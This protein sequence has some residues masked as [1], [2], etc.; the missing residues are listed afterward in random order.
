MEV[1]Q[2]LRKGR[3]LRWSTNRQSIERG[4]LRGAEL[5]ELQFAVFAHGTR[6]KQLVK[7]SQQHQKPLRR[8][9][10]HIIAISA[11]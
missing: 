5:V 8:H 11:E 3:K 9:G 7:E 2:L 10:E 4:E 6:R 1:L